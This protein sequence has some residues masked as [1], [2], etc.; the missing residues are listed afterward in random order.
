LSYN[1]PDVI[2]LAMIKQFKNGFKWQIM[3]NYCMMTCQQCLCKAFRRWFDDDLL[4]LV[5]AEKTKQKSFFFFPVLKK[6]FQA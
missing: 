3:A 5:L 4:F 1:L 6:G 2:V